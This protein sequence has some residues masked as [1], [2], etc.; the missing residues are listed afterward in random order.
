[1]PLFDAVLFDLDGTL[2]DTAPEI[3]EALNLC[4][5]QL[6]FPRVDALKLRAWIGMGT[7]NLICE[8]LAERQG[9]DGPI[10]VDSVMPLFSRHYRGLAGK[11]S[12]PYPGA[13][14]TLAALHARGVPMGLVSNK[15]GEFARQLLR[16][17][18]IDYAFSV[19][20][21]GDT[22]EAKKPSPLTLHHC[23]RA[24]LTTPPRTLLVGDSEIDVLTARNADVPVWVVGY[25]YRKK[26]HA[27]ELC[28]DR[29]ID[30]LV[31][32]LPAL[33]SRTPIWMDRA[34]AGAE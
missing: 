18:R 8:A 5:V 2:I 16:A 17:H 19:R 11:L 9:P 7:R 26:P 10:Q 28:A 22:L 1:M 30:S 23:T 25:G 27:H 12:R 20:V 31:D 33:R 4:L 34:Q 3:G 13:L 6:G 24:L 21:F 14:E 32:V 29:V 15:E